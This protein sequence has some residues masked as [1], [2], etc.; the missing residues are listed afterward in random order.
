MTQ[1]STARP[2]GNPP[3]ERARRIAD[4][5]EAL[6][7]GRH[8]WLSTAGDDRPHLVPLAYVW[9]GEQLFCA[10]KEA[11]R[12]VRNLRS[13][14]MAKVAIGTAQD[15]VLIEADVTVS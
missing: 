9:D 7:A 13:S 1:V 2:R 3:R 5:R 10:T 6:R 12:S 15:V 11:N 4:V 8:L 14:G